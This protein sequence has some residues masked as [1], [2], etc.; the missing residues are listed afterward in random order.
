MIFLTKHN[1][2]TNKILHVIPTHVC[3]YVF[4]FIM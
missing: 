4:M 2:N 3:V 1:K